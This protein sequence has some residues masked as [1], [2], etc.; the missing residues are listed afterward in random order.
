MLS[1]SGQVHWTLINLFNKYVCDDPP[2]RGRKHLRFKRESCHTSVVWNML[3][4]FL[5]DSCKKKLIWQ[6]GAEHNLWSCEFCSSRVLAV[7]WWC[8]Y[9]WASHPGVPSQTQ[10]CLWY[11]SLCVW[12]DESHQNICW[13]SWLISTDHPQ[14]RH[15]LRQTLLSGQVSS[16]KQVDYDLHKDSLKIPFDLVVPDC[17]WL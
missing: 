11:S 8:M 5:N 12:L 1:H 6:P 9:S 16:T 10:W 3:Q 17:L 14:T 15:Y 2:L 4:P 13:Q 7:P